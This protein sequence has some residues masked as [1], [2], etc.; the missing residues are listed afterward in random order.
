MAESIPRSRLLGQRVYV[1][2]IL[3]IIDKLFFQEVE[4]FF[5]KP[6]RKIPIGPYSYLQNVKY[7]NFY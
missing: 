4:A 7:L 6:I 2:V 3:V 5:H 1:F